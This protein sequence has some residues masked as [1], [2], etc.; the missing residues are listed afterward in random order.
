MPPHVWMVVVPFAVAVWW[1]SQW[2]LQPVVS[3]WRHVAAGLVSILLWIYL[4]FASTRALAGS[5]E[6]YAYGS[7]ALAFVSVFMA[8]V[9]FL[10]VIL[11]LLLW[12]EETASDAVS[13]ADGQRLRPGD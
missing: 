9:S 1:T 7:E 4:S 8:L 12:V 6:Q 10:G 3:R 11:G 13:E 2:L 5:P